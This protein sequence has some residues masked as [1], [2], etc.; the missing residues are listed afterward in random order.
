[1]I[2]GLE[3]VSS[4]ELKASDSAVTALDLAA[5]LDDLRVLVEPGCREAGRRLVWAPPGLPEP[6]PQQPARSR[7][8]PD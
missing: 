7:R 3:R 2:E 8:F 4:V 6:G 1:V 5:V